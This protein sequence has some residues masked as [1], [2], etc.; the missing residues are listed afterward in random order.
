MNDLREFW[1]SGAW[2]KTTSGAWDEPR[3]AATS[4]LS[5]LALTGAIA[6]FFGDGR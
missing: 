3:Q 5:V 1:G 6:Y 4:L 2:P